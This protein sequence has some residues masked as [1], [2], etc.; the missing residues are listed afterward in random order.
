MDNKELIKAINE[1]KESIDGL[2]G[3]ID[4]LTISVDSLDTI[5]HDVR[6]SLDNLKKKL[7]KDDD[8]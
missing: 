4:N 7:D 8:D 6:D 2:A 1:L 5:N 3:S